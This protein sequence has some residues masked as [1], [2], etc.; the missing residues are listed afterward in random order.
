MKSSLAAERRRH[1]RMSFGLMSAGLV[2]GISVSN[3]RGVF[4]PIYGI[5]DAIAATARAFAAIA[6]PEPLHV[7]SI[8][9]PPLPLRRLTDAAP[10]LRA[11]GASRANRPV[12]PVFNEA[13]PLPSVPNPQ[14]LVAQF[15]GF[16]AMPTPLLR[17]A[18]ALPA[19]ASLAPVQPMSPPIVAK[20]AN[21]SGQPVECPTDDPGKGATE[22]TPPVQAAPVPEPASWAMMIAGFGIVGAAQRAFGRRRARKL[23]A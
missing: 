14:A 2:A 6:V 5:D 7:D 17:G 20:C 16:P 1:W 23:R 9:T 8:Y 11:V 10:L 22:P 3:E 15:D 12:V 18:G 4:M 21:D 13:S 19:F